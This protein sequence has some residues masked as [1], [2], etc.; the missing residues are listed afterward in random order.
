MKNSNINSALRP[1]L[2]NLML[3]NSGLSKFLMRNYHILLFTIFTALGS[4]NYYSSKK[5]H[6]ANAQFK[7]TVA[8]Q[9]DIMIED[10]RSNVVFTFS[11][12]F[13]VLLRDD[14]PMMAHRPAK[15]SKVPYNVVTWLTVPGN[16]SN[17]L[18][19]IKKDE[20][21]QGDGFDAR[22]LD[23]G[24]SN[25]TANLFQSGGSVNLMPIRVEQTDSAIVF[26]YDCKGEPFSFSAWLSLPEKGYPKM[27]F[28]FAPDVDG[29]YS[30][31]FIG[32]P[33]YELNNVTE[34][35]QP[36]IWQELR[37]PDQPY[38]TLAYRC[39][40]P[41][42]LVQSADHT[43]GVVADPSEYPFDPLPLADNSRFG[44]AVRNENGQ[45]QTL[46]FAPV[47]GGF[48]SKMSV[49]QAFQ[50]SMQL[51]IEP[52]D[53][54]SAYKKM[55]TDVYGFSDY[56]SNDSHQL[57]RTLDNMLDYGMSHWS[58]FIDSL[59][60]CAYSTDVP[61]AV[62]NVSSL[63]PLELALVT[64][65]KDIYENRAYPI[66]EYL[67]S[68][69]KFLF[70]LDK[71]QKIQNPS[72]KLDGPAAPVSELAALYDISQGTSKAFL[73][74]AEKEYE[75]TRIRNLGD[76]EIG[77]TW[78]NSLALYRATNDR[79]FLDKAIVGAKEYIRNRVNKPSTDFN[80][81][82][83]ALFFW[84]GFTPDYIGL[85]QLFE[86]TGSKEFLEAAHQGALRYTQFVWFSPEISEGEI[87]V[88]KGG[89]AP[90]Y[91]YLKGKGHLQMEA[92]EELVPAWR[93]SAIGLTPESSGTCNGHRGI[94]MANYGPWLYRIGYHAGDKFLMDIARSAVIGRYSN[95]PGYHINTAR[96]TIYEK[97]DYPLRPFKQLSVNSFH[98]NHIWPHMSI[99]VDHLVTDVY[100]KSESAIDFPSEFI[101]GYAYLQ[102][103]FYGHRQGV[104]YG[105]KAWLWMPRKLLEL[106]SNEI[107][108]LSARGK[109]NLYIAFTNQSKEAQKFSFELNREL[110]GFQSKHK[111]K[112]WKNNKDSG[113]GALIDGSLN[114]DIMPEGITVVA[115]E[116]MNIKPEFQNKMLQNQLNG[117]DGI[118]FQSLDFGNGR[119][120]II[121]MGQGMKNAYIYLGQDDDVFSNVVLNYA[122][123]G[124]KN[125]SME[126]AHYPFEFTIPLEKK[127][128]VSFFMEGERIDGS[129]S[130][131]GNIEL[132]P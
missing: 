35:W 22:V 117:S 116:D 103:K 76:M 125:V 68:R 19:E 70:S 132:G 113:E 41:S 121:D 108:Y 101:E 93:L 58:Y 65:E 3:F 115:I 78:Q 130:R 77:D 56:R 90:L 102:S 104:V 120:M 67:L 4:C 21:Q 9:H 59:K 45:A 15:I 36:M 37:F 57:N 8:A 34:I 32:A 7:I 83:A 40:L 1:D 98:F 62:K 106:S 29:Y 63:N 24:V 49:G 26:H 33:S 72:R 71:K 114:L 107:N 82:N 96:T 60:G 91:W 95:F 110:T 128:Q 11:P 75:G 100:V 48:D 16:E 20:S 39:P 111:L 5:I 46:L 61:G 109:D 50:F 80:D 69:E 79:S 99:L 94:F 87:L 124:G 89:K 129:K 105:E 74:L 88:N 10:R 92:D 12:N 84:I 14:D 118:H 123:D 81:P 27:T 112:I 122:I 126:D 97:P 25:R 66:M 28:K 30:I 55:A 64:D 85:F 44:V 38:M 43:L 13:K 127:S 53:M 131:S 17:M 52:Q 86:A 47:M 54:L 51:Y 23:A 31:G 119:A 73:T 18:D 2:L 6:F 42:A